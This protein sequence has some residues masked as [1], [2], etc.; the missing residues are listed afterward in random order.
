MKKFYNNLSISKKLMFTYFIFIILLLM[1]SGVSYLALSRQK[2]SVENICKIRLKAWLRSAEIINKADKTYCNIFKV[3]S[4][5]TAGY[6]QE[7][8]DQLSKD[9]MLAADE[10]I[11]TVK[12]II[13]AGNIVQEE[14]KFYKN[15]LNNL[16]KLKNILKETLEMMG[17]GIGVAS[18]YLMNAEDRFI[19]LHKELNQLVKYEKKLMD[20]DYNYAMS[21]FNTA[22]VTAFVLG[23]FAIL[24]YII[25]Y[26]YARREIS[27]RLI[28]FQKV[29]VRIM[30]T[31]DLSKKKIVL[32]EVILHNDEIGRIAI[33]FSHLIDILREL[34]I[35]LQNS[36]TTISSSSQ[37]LTDASDS[38]SESAIKENNMVSNIREIMEVVKHRHEFRI[39]TL[40]AK[41]LVY[42]VDDGDSLQNFKDSAKFLNSTPQQVLFGFVIKHITAV[43]DI[44]RSGKKPGD[45]WI[46]EYLGDI[47]NYLDLMEC[48]WAE[49]DNNDDG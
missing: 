48:L 19:L 32:N 11:E 23:I 24:I 15:S 39:S 1:I 46:S 38:L 14:K 18:K 4:W 22:K 12:G 33:E 37:E 20:K 13:D 6:P 36:G 9:Q 25:V 47:H 7:K 26:F 30:K 41:S 3:L 29:I 8:I 2:D 35:R 5:K 45:R 42:T 44:V 10:I 40:V 31:K 49:E 43:K 21:G 17:Q 16:V 34:L 27:S 28:N